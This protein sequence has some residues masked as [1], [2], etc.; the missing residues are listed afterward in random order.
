MRE[1]GRTTREMDVVWKGIP[2]VIDMRA[3][4]AMENLMGMEYT[5]GLTAKFTKASGIKV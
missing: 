5:R 4:S 3:I 1:S 2:T